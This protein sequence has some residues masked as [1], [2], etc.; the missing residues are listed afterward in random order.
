MKNF[1]LAILFTTLFLILSIGCKKEDEYTIENK[2]VSGNMTYVRTGFV[3]LSFDSTGMVPLSAQIS[4]DGTGSIT[5]IGAVTMTSN[6][7]FNFITGMGTDF[8]S[9][10]KGDKSEDSFELDGSS[11]V[12]PNGSI[13]VTET[14]KNGKG[15]FSKIKGGGTTTVILNANQTAG[16][17]QI[18]W[19]ISY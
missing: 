15:K 17:G 10:F 12:Q 16:T 13:I 9:S 6:F 2:D 18:N 8:I 14:I 4:M 1:N 7:K 19:K 11:Q 3:P 5:D